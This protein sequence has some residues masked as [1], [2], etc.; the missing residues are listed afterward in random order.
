MAGNEEQRDDSAE[1]LSS[2]ADGQ[3]PTD[4][5]EPSAVNPYGP[6]VRP[7]PG[8]VVPAVGPRP[9]NL[10]K[11]A[12]IPRVTPPPIPAVQAPPAQPTSAAPAAAPPAEAQ[13]EEDEHPKG[14]SRSAS[15]S[16]EPRLKDWLSLKGKKGKK[17]KEKEKPGR[18]GGRRREHSRTTTPW[19]I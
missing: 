15:E 5:P 2:Q 6:T 16:I 19:L 4:K 9:V 8:K 13:T 18:R 3:V 14:H 7:P 12:Q 17:V 1:G 11:P 10:P